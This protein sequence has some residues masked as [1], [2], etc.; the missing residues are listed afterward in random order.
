[1]SRNLILPAERFVESRSDDW[2]L[3]RPPKNTAQAHRRSVGGL[4]WRVNQT[5]LVERM[6]PGSPRTRKPTGIPKRYLY[7]LV[8][9]QCVSAAIEAKTCS[10]GQLSRKKLPRTF[11]SPELFHGVNNGM[12]GCFASGPRGR[13]CAGRCSSVVPAEEVGCGGLV[14][15][16]RGGKILFMDAPLCASFG[17]SRESPP[18]EL[19]DLMSPAL[20][21][22]HD[23]FLYDAF[24]SS[25]GEARRR[26]EAR[27]GYSA[28]GASGFR[29]N[30][31]RSLD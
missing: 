23:R 22:L 20:R 28:A 10:P 12:G 27:E 4:E 19:G 8:L 16:D 14:I 2:Q 24:F 9:K 15:S 5:A 18:G 25:C 26:I 3:A 13:F 21:E 30:C 6:Y 29:R 31:W 11:R 7:K 1:M 17:F